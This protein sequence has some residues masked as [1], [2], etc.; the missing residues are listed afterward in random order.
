MILPLI[1]SSASGSSISFWMARRSGRAPSAGS[2]PF[3]SR[4]FSAP[5][6]IV[7]VDVVLLQPVA[8]LIEQDL[9]DP[10]HVRAA[11]ARLK[12]MISS[13][14]FRNS[15]LKTFLTSSI[16]VAFICG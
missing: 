8:D 11:R 2:N 9:D 14:R 6:V 3:S 4:R 10:L 13:I 15:G 5:G 7:K 12:T 1:T 16:T